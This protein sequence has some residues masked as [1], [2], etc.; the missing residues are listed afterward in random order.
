[1]IRHECYY[2]CHISC[3]PVSLFLHIFKEKSSSLGFLHWGEKGWFLKRTQ[4]LDELLTGVFVVTWLWPLD[5]WQEAPI[6][7]RD[8]PG[9]FVS[10]L[11][12]RWTPAPND[13]QMFPRIPRCSFPK[14]FVFIFQ[15][16]GLRPR[17]LRA[18]RCGKPAVLHRVRPLLQ[19]G[20]SGSRLLHGV[21]ESQAA[22]FIV[23]FNNH[24]IRNPVWKISPVLRVS[25]MKSTI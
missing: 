18:F 9:N 10:W 16:A 23:L 6:E 4:T 7:E 2:W 13:V 22:G 17:D 14:Q 15:E 25:Y 5:L 11:I 3:F 1:M 24:E 8:A 20:A 21:K 12:P 19:G